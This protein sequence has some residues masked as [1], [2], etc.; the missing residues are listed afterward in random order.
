MFKR[1]AIPEFHIGDGVFRVDMIDTWNMKIYFLG[2]AMGPVQKFQPEIAPGLMR[3]IRVDRAD[4]G[5]P[6]G[7]VTE[8]MEQ[9]GQRPN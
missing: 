1:P 4:P 3:F 9:F 8:L 6:H 5:A 7:T 2:Y